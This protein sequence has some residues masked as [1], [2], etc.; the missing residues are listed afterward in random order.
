MKK[1]TLDEIKDIEFGILS[2]FAKFCRENGMRFFL[3]NGTLLGAVKYG[4]FIPW[5]DDID[6]LMPREDYD[7]FIA[8]FEDTERYRLFS[9]S[10]SEG[11]RFP[12][13]KLCDRKTIK[14][15]ETELASDSLKMG[16]CIDIFPIDGFSNLEISSRMRALFI[17]ICT[18]LLCLSA[19]KDTQ[20][21]SIIIKLAK[22]IGY[23]KLRRLH[24]FASRSRGEA[25]YCGNAV[26]TVRGAH[27][28]MHR[29][30][31][32]DTVEV[33]FCGG[34]FPAPIGFDEY[35]R[36]MY[37][38]YEKEPPINKRSSHHSFEA[39]LNGGDL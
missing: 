8:E 16:L 24:S 26:W 38:D 2:A 21:R 25:K 1:L 9:E 17:R 30:V 13:A 35:L 5:D 4:G 7:R 31:F 23:E 36:S 10:R 27:E 22:A 11:Y 19:Q 28:V 32:S 12:F 33:L 34:Q 14:S 29:R 18:A 6:V 39:Y 20:K 15:E 37:G 3:S